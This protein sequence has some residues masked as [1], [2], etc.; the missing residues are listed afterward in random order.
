MKKALFILLLLLI[1]LAAQEKSGDVGLTKKLNV[2]FP[3]EKLMAAKVDDKSRA[4]V[5]ILTA[6][7]SG[8]GYKYEMEFIGLEPGEYNLIDYLRTENDEPLTFKKH[9]IEVGTSLAVGF[10]GELLDYQKTSRNLIPWYKKINYAVM[11][12]W[13]LLLPVIILYG[14]KKK[15]ADEI[16]VEEEKSINEKIRGL[17]SSMGNS[18]SKELWQKVESLI[19]QHWCEKKNLQGMPMHEAIIKLKEDDEAGPF[20]LKLEKGIHSQEF[21]DE[22]GITALIQH[23]TLEGGSV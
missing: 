16:V 23:L 19:F 21:K 22:K 17:L 3:G 13:A 9:Q 8:D 18:S 12:I 6:Q 20:I 2:T 4:M 10:D 7:K 11:A 1:S 14:R 5:R 15:K